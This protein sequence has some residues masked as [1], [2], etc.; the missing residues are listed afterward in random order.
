[1]RQVL[2]AAFHDWPFFVWLKTGLPYQS[3]QFGGSDWWNHRISRG[4]WCL[5]R[6]A[7]WWV[8]KRSHGH[9]HSMGYHWLLHGIGKAGKNQQPGDVARDTSSRIGQRE[10]RKEMVCGWNDP[11]NSSP[12]MSISLPGLRWKIWANDDNSQNWRKTNSCMASRL[13]SKTGTN[14]DHPQRLIILMDGTNHPQVH[15]FQC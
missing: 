11:N 14:P 10:W 5:L 1:M 13:H 8:A 2:S 7:L 12:Q 3:H 6:H 4:K 9:C 15:W